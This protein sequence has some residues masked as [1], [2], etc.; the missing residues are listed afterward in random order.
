MIQRLLSFF[1]YSLLSVL[2][3]YAQTENKYIRE[4]NDFYKRNNFTAAEKSYSRSIEKNK[5]AASSYFF[6][7][8]KAS[9][10]LN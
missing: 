3:G 7:L 8:Y 5:V 1:L 4:G 9:P 10:I 6:C 2:S